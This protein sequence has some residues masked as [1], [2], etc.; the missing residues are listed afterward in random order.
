MT[1]PELSS[2]LNQRHFHRIRRE[3]AVQYSFPGSEDDLMLG[4]TMDMSFGGVR[5]SL[6][7][8]VP[9]GQVITLRVRG[10]EEDI[11]FSIEGVVVWARQ[12]DSPEGCEV[13]VQFPDLSPPQVMGI[14]ALIGTDETGDTEKRQYVRLQ[15]RLAVRMRRTEGWPQK[16]LM[17][18]ALNIGL[19]GMAVV[20]EKEC[21]ESE[22]Y[23]AEIL[24][25]ASGPPACVLAEVLES[26]LAPEGGGW[27]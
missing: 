19:G 1:E 12:D 22:V 7:E 16:R 25:D 11:E 26:G 6:A 18:S 15:K 5:L 3:L 20:A 27:L 23:A 9:P 24:L 13:G 4:H 21:S 2:L 10:E 17:A 14:I 8:G